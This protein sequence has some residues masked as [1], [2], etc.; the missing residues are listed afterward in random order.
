MGKFVLDLA[1]RYKTA[2]G[3]VAYDAYQD[4]KAKNKSK[5]DGGNP[6]SS[7]GFY[8]KSGFCF[9]DMELSREGYLLKLGDPDFFARSQ[10]ST[11]FVGPPMISVSR[12]KILSITTPDRSSSEIVENFGKKAND[13][14]IKGVIV[15][16]AEH[17]YPGNQVKQL[18]QFNDIEGY[19]DVCC[20]FLNDLGIYSLHITSMD[21]IT[22]VEG[23]EDT[24]SYSFSARSAQPSEFYLTNK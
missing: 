13:I 4:Y 9:S 8:V 1:V 22:G 20:Q 6:F 19:F 21:E 2:F 11:L 3:F 5:Q 18:R 12:E 10:A 14:K 24:L 7:N 17:H 23:F 15:D 16:M